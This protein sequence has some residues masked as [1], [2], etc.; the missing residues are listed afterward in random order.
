[1]P[2]SQASWLTDLFFLCLVP[3]GIIAEKGSLLSHTAIIS[4]E[5]NKPA[6]VNVKDCTAILKTGDLVELDA[7]IGIVKILKE[8]KTN[9]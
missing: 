8:G 6:I 4:R 2:L 7:E 3:V 9:V 5:L 1:M